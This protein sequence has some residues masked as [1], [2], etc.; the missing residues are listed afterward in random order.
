[1][2][3]L[4]RTWPIVLA[5][6][7]TWGLTTA[8]VAAQAAPWRLVQG[9][10]GVLFVIRGDVKHRIVPAPMTEADMAIPEAVAW[11]DGVMLV[12]APGRSAD[13][14]VG[15]QAAPPPPSRS[16]AKRIGDTTVLTTPSGL[17]IAITVNAVEDNVPPGRF[18]DAPT[19]RYV[20][21]DWTI[22]NEGVIGA[23]I[24]RLHFKLQTAD[25]FV[26]QRA[27]EV[28]EPGLKTDTIG[29]GQVVRG[30]LTYDVPPGARVVSAIYQPPG[31]QQFLI[32]EL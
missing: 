11:E 12:A 4:K 10:D 15:Q 20:A 28:R 26:I 1:M 18:D 16:S 24:N 21:V 3:G 19:G 32:A 13:P 17:R 23:D 7:A 14:P 30:W 27:S 9:G 25:G 2:L 22:K 5:V 31:A 8:A 6:V 29:P